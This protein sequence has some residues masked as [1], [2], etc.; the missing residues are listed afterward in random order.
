[1][2]E[3]KPLIE[4]QVLREDPGAVSA[5][6]GLP[7]FIARPADA[8]A[9]YGF[10]LLPESEKDGFVFGVITNSRT[11]APASWGDAYVMAPDGTRAG[12][13]WVMRGPVTEVVFP[14]EPGRWGVYQFLFKHPVLSDGDL[15]RN[16]HAILP[17]L[18]E[19]YAA[20]ISTRPS[21]APN[22]TDGSA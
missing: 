19:L 12:I 2:V 9:Y 1:V 10:P 17:R 3:K 13:V 16:L 4:G 6:P 20:A 21:A 11:D 5:T 14:P 8:P 7:A 15:I 22:E 18:K